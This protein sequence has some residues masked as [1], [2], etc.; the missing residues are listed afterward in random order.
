MAQSFILKTFSKLVIVLHNH[1]KLLQLLNLDKGKV[2][3]VN[4]DLMPQNKQNNNRLL[5]FIDSLTLNRI[6]SKKT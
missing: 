6:Y 5:S 4:L 3:V 1:L 2:P